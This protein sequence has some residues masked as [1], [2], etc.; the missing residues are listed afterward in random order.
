DKPAG[1]LSC[2]GRGDDKL[3]SVQTRVPHLVPHAWGSLLGHRLDQATSGLLA[4]GLHPAAH[5]SLQQQFEARTVQK[6]Y[7]A[8]L[9]GEVNGE[10]GLIELPQ[11][12]DV[13]RRP[14]QIYDPLH[15]KMAIT[16]WRLVERTTT[17]AGVRSRVSFLPVT[18]RTHQLRLASAH[19][20]G[21]ACPIAGDALYGDVS[22]APRLLL[23]AEELTLSHP[24]TSAPVTFRS[25]VPF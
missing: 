20:R 3:D 25:P 9:V 18:G 5:R 8:V 6:R 21:L 13:E 22:S 10:E 4:I 16:R 12:L 19:S 11:R 7:E 2:P 17:S 15:G 24:R 14:L 1:L 23:H